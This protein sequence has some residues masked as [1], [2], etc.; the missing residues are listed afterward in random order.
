VGDVHRASDRIEQAD[1]LED[2]GDAADELD[3]SEEARSRAV[4]LFL[5]NVPEADRSKPAAIAASLYAGGL[6]AGEERSQTEVA[7]AVGVS[8]L[9]VGSRWKERLR[10][11]GFDPPAW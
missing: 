5:S 10:E 11:A 8:R 2:L 9:A 1:W 7:D 4:E 6:L 3:L